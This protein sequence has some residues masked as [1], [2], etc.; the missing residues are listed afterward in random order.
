MSERLRINGISL[1]SRRQVCFIWRLSG[2]IPLLLLFWLISGCGPPKASY[3]ASLLS[4]NPTER[5]SAIKYAAAIQDFSVIDILVDRLEDEDEAV[6]MFAIL[7]LERLTGH[8]QGYEYHAPASE[9]WRAVQRWRRYLAE[10]ND[11][12]DESSGG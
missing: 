1:G 4:E 3:P 5:A 9:R 6:R 8:R 2:T 11:V 7:A 12:S 10:R